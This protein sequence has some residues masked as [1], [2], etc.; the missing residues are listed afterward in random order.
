MDFSAAFLHDYGY[1]SS[2]YDNCEIDGNLQ[3]LNDFVK[4]DEKAPLPKLDDED[5]IWHKYK[6]MHFI[7]ALN[8]INQE[9]REFKEKEKQIQ[10]MANRK[11]LNTQE[12]T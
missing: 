9:I 2:V 10:N 4:K 6:D 12:I 1:H 3:V 8:C 7:E 11:N 5:M